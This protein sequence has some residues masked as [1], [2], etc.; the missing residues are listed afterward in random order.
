M[1][2][3]LLNGSP[4]NNGK[5]A[6]ALA[7]VE[8][9]LKE[10]GVET[11]NMWI[12]NK[13][14]RGCID[15]RNCFKTQRCAFNDD[16]CNDIIEALIDADGIVIGSPIY[17]GSANGA[18][19]SILDR[20]FYAGSTFAH[21][22]DGKIGASLATGV[23]L[24]GTATLDRINKYYISSAMKIV[25]APEYT[26]YMSDVPDARKARITENFKNLGRLIAKEA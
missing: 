7:L 6:E 1:K 22:F 10:K 24:G 16:I 3:I 14:V 15:C 18:L 13:P 23:W 4:R 25:T 19:C 17:F 2:I 12:G 11:V 20:V 21:L 8:E 9:G 5:T 26:L